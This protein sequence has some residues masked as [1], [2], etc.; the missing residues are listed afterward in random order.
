M[1]ADRGAIIL[2]GGRSERMGRDKALLPFGPNEVLLQRVVRI[3]AETV[4][5]ERIICVAG[6][7][8]SLPP[9]PTAVRVVRDSEPHLGPLAGLAAGLDVL[10][11]HPT[12][13]FA[14]PC[15]A[16]LLTPAFA[17]R[18]F[19]L[20]AAHDIALLRDGEQLYPLPAVYRS[21]VLSRA[22]RLLA[23]GERSLKSLVAECDV[24]FVD[25]DE[26][27][28]FDTDSASLSSCNSPEDYEWALARAFPPSR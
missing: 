28:E 12:A 11:G 5:A 10:A 18:M 16:P 24:R 1:N 20:L 13:V 19:E 17:Q 6:A 22:Q 4:P 14:C 2:C 25:A 27:R 3:V 9:L 23:N 7:D 15:D 8:Q 26:L 21:N